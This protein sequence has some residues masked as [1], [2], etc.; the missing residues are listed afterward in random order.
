MVIEK[1]ENIDKQKKQNKR[2]H[3]TT[4]WRTS[5]LTIWSVSIFSCAGVYGSKKRN[6]KHYLIQHE[7]YFSIFASA[8]ML[9]HIPLS[10]TPQLTPSLS[11]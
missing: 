2:I 6:H 4:T 3:S 1:K 9:C 5:Q 8:L 10:D 7:V 11:L